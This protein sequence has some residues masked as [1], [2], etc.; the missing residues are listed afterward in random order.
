MIK[1]ASVKKKCHLH[2]LDDNKD[3]PPFKETDFYRSR[4]RRGW[5]MLVFKVDRGASEAGRNESD[6]GNVL[7]ECVWRLCD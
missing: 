7:A 1:G 6:L 3:F 2:Y 4:S 5:F